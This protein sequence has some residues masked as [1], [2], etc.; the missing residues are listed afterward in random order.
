MPEEPT[1]F[2]ETLISELE[3]IVD[4]TKQEDLRRRHPYI[5]V[6]TEMVESVLYYDE[7]VLALPIFV[8]EFTSTELSSISSFREEVRHRGADDWP[9]IVNAASRLLAHLRSA[10]ST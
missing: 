4:P 2:R 1:H 7:K 10:P 3:M 9:S 6:R 5:D 8:A